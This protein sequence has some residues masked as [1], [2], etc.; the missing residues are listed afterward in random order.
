MLTG[1][2]IGKVERV[3]EGRERWEEKS[4]LKSGKMGEH[5]TRL[6]MT[7]FGAVLVFTS[8]TRSPALGNRPI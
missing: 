2:K 7:T 4:Q 5:V 6:A 8:A 1:R 3:K